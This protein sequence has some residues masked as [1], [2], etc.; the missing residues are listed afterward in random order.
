MPLEPISEEAFRVA[1]HAH[2]YLRGRWL[3]LRH[4]AR[5]V[6]ELR[7]E[8]VLE[9]GPGPQPFVPGSDSLDVDPSFGPTHVHDAG[10]AP[11]PIASG[12]YDLVIGLQCWEH[13]EGRQQDAF[14]EAMR[15][16]G[17]G[18]HVLLSVPFMWRRT[19]A[20]HSGIGV[21]RIREWTLGVEAK[22]R[23]LVKKPE[24]RKRMVLLFRGGDVHP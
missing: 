2:G 18:G 4:V 10:A 16:A 19:N 17:P 11:W 1:A 13:F 20:T 3:Y 5:I 21:A 14:R 24:D 23:L 7:P 12:S 15:V 8:R 9:I 22:R 6:T